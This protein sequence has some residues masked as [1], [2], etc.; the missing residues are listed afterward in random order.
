MN[1][2]ELCQKRDLLDSQMSNTEKSLKETFKDDWN[3]LDSKIQAYNEYWEAYEDVHLQ[4]NTTRKNSGKFLEDDFFQSESFNAFASAM[5]DLESS[6]SKDSSR[7]SSLA[8]DKLPTFSG[9]LDD[10]QTFRDTY[11]SK[12]HENTDLTV[13]QKLECL[14]SV[15]GNSHLYKATE[16]DYFN[17]WA[18]FKTYYDNGEIDDTLSEL[19]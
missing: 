16:E 2:Q 17:V 15:V 4:L 12:I 6:G 13:A 7:K 9:K 1:A 3:T 18:D 14:K 11:I 10:W 8:D 5:H 19:S